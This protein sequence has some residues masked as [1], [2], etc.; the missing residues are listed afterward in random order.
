MKNLNS[1]ACLNSL[2]RAKNRCY[3]DL[4]LIVIARIRREQASGGLNT[5][6]RQFR[7]DSNGHRGGPAG[8]RQSQ[9][10]HRVYS[11]E[12]RAGN[13]AFLSVHR[14][15][16]SSASRCDLHLVHRSGDGYVAGGLLGLREVRVRY[17]VKVSEYTKLS[18]YHAKSGIMKKRICSNIEEHRS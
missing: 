15:R 10:E 3:D 9:V 7:V 17:N 18:T 11:G 4:A 5:A 13:N 1:L 14:S 8:I 2:I 16:N 12:Q 6:R